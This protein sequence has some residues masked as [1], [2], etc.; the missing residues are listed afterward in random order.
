MKK[1]GVV[2][3]GVCLLG[4]L[5]MDPSSLALIKRSQTDTCGLD[6]D[7]LGL[8]VLWK[9]SKAEADDASSKNGI[10]LAMF[11]VFGSSLLGSI[12]SIDNYLS[13]PP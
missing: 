13:I 4:D 1:Y 7:L 2:S 10:F 11:N 5:D 3:P 8:G 9:S 12:L 6:D